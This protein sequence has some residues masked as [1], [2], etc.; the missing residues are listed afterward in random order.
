MTLVSSN[1][2]VEAVDREGKVFD[3]V[4][5]IYARSE[6]GDLEL[7]LDINS[8]IYSLRVGDHF[9]MSIDVEISKAK[10][11]ST[12]EHWHPSMIENTTVSQYEYVMHGIVYR[13][14]VDSAQHRAK[15][16]VSFGGLLMSLDGSQ[17]IVSNYTRGKE[18]YIFI[19]KRNQ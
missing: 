13:F 5:R 11:T 9:T 16:F 14:E 2:T 4:S 7:Q 3:N 6:N 15:I 17:Q 18:I 10:T 1:Y 12:N 8:Q 19:R